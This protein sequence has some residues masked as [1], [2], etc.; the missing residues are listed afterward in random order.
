MGR[1]FRVGVILDV[2]ALAIVPL[3]VYLLGGATLGM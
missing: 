1:M 2:I 3:M